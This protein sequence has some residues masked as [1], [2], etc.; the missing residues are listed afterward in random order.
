[1]VFLM[2]QVLLGCDTV[3]GVC[4]CVCVCVCGSHLTLV[5]EGGMIL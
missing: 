2:I 4:V 5:Y 3:S 1:M